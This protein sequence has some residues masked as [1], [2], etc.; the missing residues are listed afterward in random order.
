[1]T[2]CP[3]IIHPRRRPDR[4]FGTSR[5]AALLLFVW[6]TAPLAAFGQQE[7]PV[8]FY[9]VVPGTTTSRELSAMKNWGTVRS[10]ENEGN[11][12]TRHYQ[13]GIWPQVVV[14]IRNDVVQL[15]DVTP[16]ERTRAEKLAEALQ[17]G[18]VTEARES[19]FVAAATA[20]LATKEEYLILKGDAPNVA[21]FVRDDGNKRYVR[22][23]RLFSTRS[24]PTNP[25]KMTTPGPVRLKTGTPDSSQREIA[26]AALQ[27]LEG[28]H[29][30][31][32]KL[33]KARAELWIRLYIKA[34]DPSQRYFLQSDIDRFQQFADSL[35]TDAR[36]GRIDFGWEII[37]VYGRR[38]EKCL[39]MQQAFATTV[40]DFSV[41]EEV[42]RVRT[43]FPRDSDEQ[44]DLC[45]R[46]TKYQLLTR[47]HKGMSLSEAREAVLRHLD[48][49]RTVVETMDSDNVL[50]MCV[51][52]LAESFDTHCSFYTPREVNELEI[53]MRIQMV[54]IGARL[55]IVDGFV[56][57]TNIVPGSAAATD[58]RLEVGDQ[59]LS[60]ATDGGAETMLRK[61][62]LARAVKLIRGTEGSK[63]RLRV[64]KAKGGQEQ[65]VDLVR[66]KLVI[67]T[68]RARGKIFNERGADGTNRIGVIRIPTFYNNQNK[69][70][71][72]STTLDTRK[73][74]QEMKADGVDVIVLDL[75]SNPGGRFSEC[76]RFAGL[77][78]NPGTVIQAK[79][80]SGRVSPYA[81][82]GEKIAW[83]GPLVVCVNRYSTSGTEMVVAAL[84]DYR[85]A[86]IV[87]DTR[88]FGN[89]TMQ[90]VLDV[91]KTLKKDEDSPALGAVRVT[92]GQLYR[93]NGQSFQLDGVV[94]DITLSS[95]WD[96]DRY[97]ERAEANPLSRDAVRPAGISPHY[98]ITSDL[99]G[100]LRQQSERRR[101]ADSDF[102]A[103]GERVV[104]LQRWADQ[105]TIGLNKEEF[106]A[107]ASADKTAPAIDAEPKR[108]PWMDE[109]LSI[110][111]DLHAH[112]PWL[113]PYAAGM[114]NL[115]ARKYQRAISEFSVPTTTDVG[116]REL[117]RAKLVAK[118]NS[119]QWDAALEDAKVL[120]QKRIPVRIIK[121]SQLKIGEKS[122]TK[123]A[124]GARVAVTRENG[125]WLWAETLNQRKPQS[126][127][128]RP[129]DV[130]AEP[131]GR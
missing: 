55:G 124:V 30:R 28:T 13:F 5:A 66:R 95:V 78:L 19:S 33:D 39:R 24:A 63:L 70:N 72:V 90:N 110:A 84:Q 29:A 50:D 101:A 112:T 80:R 127:W 126:G 122:V 68:S 88:T 58:G 65:M 87:G 102:Q 27:T 25:P 52:A 7:N 73:I 3:D 35:V 44:R 14:A 104:R 64:R 103:A 48:D 54:G 69:A 45:R 18:E 123:L 119:G 16:P 118:A 42:Q 106:N 82:Q 92:S 75:R 41:R 79:D 8:G 117:R 34:V 115:V 71:E 67:A 62:R 22:M 114:K 36:T 37:N 105:K 100:R 99:I 59:L 11:Q 57:V 31:G 116:R 21:L 108:T 86:L 32:L 26:A 46:H 23:M 93:P 94:S 98:A 81:P 10:E 97:G 4:G 120:G 109:V 113:K 15:I 43:R 53:S 74:L 89:G 121:K 17:L 2:R 1:M 96:T 12:S 47:M 111:V 49:Q 60:A 6:L 130:E 51:T 129:D 128:I 38:F 76:I 107:W 91:R 40:E 85:R 125:G 9:G 83:S 77:F 20:G 56:T 131:P 61:M